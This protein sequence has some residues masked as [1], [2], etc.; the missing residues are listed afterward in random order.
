MQVYGEQNLLVMNGTTAAEV[1]FKMQEAIDEA[2]NSFDATIL[3][4]QK[5]LFPK[6]KPTIEEFICKVTEKM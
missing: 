1:E 5:E 6:G 3:A 2:W 4:V